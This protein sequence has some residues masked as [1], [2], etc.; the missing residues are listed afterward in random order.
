MNKNLKEKTIYAL[1]WSLFDRFGQQI[2]I[3]V[4]NIIVSNILSVD[5]Y[6]LTG[7]LALF[8]ALGTIM[9]DS[10]FSSALIQKIDVSKEEYKSVFVFNITISIILFI[11]LCL[12]TPLIANFYDKK[13]LLYIAPLVFLALPINSLGIIQNTIL[14]KEVR[15]KELAKINVITTFISG[16]AS[17]TMALSGFGVWTLAVQPSIIAFVRVIL[18]WKRSSWRPQGEYGLKYIK[19]L[20]SFASHLLLASTINTVFNNIYYFIIGKV[21]FRQVGYYNNANKIS[22]MGV[23]FL[24]T[25]IQSATYPIF[26]SIQNETERLINAFR[27]TIRFTSFISFPAM[28]GIAIIST[29]FIHLILKEEWWPCIPYIQV[30]AIGGIFT[31]L[32]AVNNNFIKVIG[33]S[34]IILRIE[35]IK[36]ILIFTAIALTIKSSILVMLEAQAV[37]RIMVYIINIY[38]SGKFTGYKFHLQLKDI[39]PYIVLTLM[40]TFISLIPICFISSD[41]LLLPLQIVLGILSYSL[42]AFLTGSKIMKESIDFILKKRT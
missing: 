4:V 10:G 3:F 12:S 39:F 18:L 19:P 40:M 9:L 29:P 28:A 17:L 42:G 20:F 22:E 11:I 37:V 6:A 15:F 38:Y 41:F 16:I 2:L 1:L 7:S 34:N 30:L 25:S 14:T 5:D 23:G 33:K 27:K 13:E 21:Y 31:I 35:F 36:I 32:T 26:S 8:T 24:H